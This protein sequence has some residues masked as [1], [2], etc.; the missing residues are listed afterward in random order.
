MEPVIIGWELQ[1][2]LLPGLS[3]ETISDFVS[4]VPNFVI[5]TNSSL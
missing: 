4:R 1:N 2:R 3:L 5:Q